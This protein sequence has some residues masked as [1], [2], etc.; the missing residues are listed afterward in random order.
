MTK[1]YEDGIID[2]LKIMDSYKLVGIYDIP[3]K[4]IEEAI[5]K[6]LPSDQKLD[7]NDITKEPKKSLENPE[8]LDENEYMRMLS[9]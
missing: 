1:S 3:I 7:L 6:L 5:I 9:Q 8:Y 2:C 4:Y